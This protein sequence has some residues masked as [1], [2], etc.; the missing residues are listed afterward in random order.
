MLQRN[1]EKDLWLTVS[2]SYENLKLSQDWP[3]CMKCSQ[4]SEN[5]ISVFETWN[6]CLPINQMVASVKSYAKSPKAFA[7]VFLQNVCIGT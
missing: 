2:Q 1:K 7:L 5:G 6:N 4:V 3:Y